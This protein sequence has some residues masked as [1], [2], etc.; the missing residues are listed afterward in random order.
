M[1]IRTQSLGTSVHICAASLR[2]THLHIYLTD[3]SGKQRKI[4]RDMRA[5]NYTH[6]H[7]YIDIDIDIDIC[8]LSVSRI[9]LGILRTAITRRASFL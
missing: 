7:T 8:Y 5:Y 1:E 9:V 2:R 3:T 4:L 6:T